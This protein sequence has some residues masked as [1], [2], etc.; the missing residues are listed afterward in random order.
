M[1]NKKILVILVLIVVLLFGWLLAFK[2]VTRIDEIKKQNDLVARA[3]GFMERELYVRAIP[4]Y[5]EATKIKTTDKMSFEVEDKLLNAYFLHEDMAKYAKIIEKRAKKN[6][7][8]LEE[9]KNT[10][11]YYVQSYKM[12]DAFKLIRLGMENTGS[13]ELETLYEEYR[14]LYR[15]RSTKYKDIEPTVNNSIMPVFDGENW[16]YIA[17]GGEVLIKPQYDS[18]TAF[19]NDG[20]AVV[21]KD[22]KYFAINK[23]GDKYGL[24]DNAEKSR[25]QDAKY[26]F[27]SYFQAERD[28]KYGFFDYDFNLV[29]S[30]LLF[31]EVTRSSNGVVVGKRGDSWVIVSTSD[32]KQVATGIEEVAVNSYGSVFTDGRGM[33]KI[34]GKWHLVNTDGKDIIQETFDYAKAP[35]SDGLIAVANSAGMW[36]FINNKGELKID[37][38]YYDAYSFSDNVAA[39]QTYDDS[40]IYIS[41]FNIPISEEHFEEA[42][43]FH[44]G[45]GQVYEDG[46][47]Q[48]IIFRYYD[49][50]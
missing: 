42:K 25:I 40:W 14:Y 5:E 10:F 11:N 28:D 6:T 16:G 36:G 48:L 13:E 18:A 33:V 50:W 29:S 32:G 31:D 21:S 9:Y 35:E 27:G 23:S 46:T 19:T 49:E 22:G 44:G 3:D 30:D 26:V 24:D 4:L 39:V 17:A 37:Y 7:A 38:Q 47:A 45:V 2:S 41:K 12:K 43:P 20:I 34:G 15:M 1:G 8:S